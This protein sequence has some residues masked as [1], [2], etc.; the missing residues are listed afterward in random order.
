M[1][2]HSFYA[3]KNIA[4][5]K[6]FVFLSE[7]NTKVTLVNP[8]GKELVV[9]KE[10]FET[11]FSVGLSEVSQYF[12]QEQIATLGK[13]KSPSRSKSA[14]GSTTR[15]KTATKKG[16]NKVGLG[17][18]WSGRYLTFYKHRIDPLGELQ[19]FEIDLEDVG[20]FAISKKDFLA[21]FNDVVVA[22]TYWQDGSFTYKSLPEKAEKFIRKTA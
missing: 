16:A 12:T 11:P 21:L 13:R 6:H 19:T 17:A 2:S 10:L 4:S 14:S 5:G 9:P 7:E 15:R 1:S 20:T 18:R 22:Q 3:I 8:Q